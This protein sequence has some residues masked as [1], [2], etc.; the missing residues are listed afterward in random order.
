MRYI[1]VYIY[2]LIYIYLC[3]FRYKSIYRNLFIF[4]HSKAAVKVRINRKKVERGRCSIFTQ[5][6]AFSF[7]YFSRDFVQHFA[8]RNWL[9]TSHAIRSNNH[10]GQ[11]EWGR[12]ECGDCRILTAHYTIIFNKQF[13]SLSFFYRDSVAGEGGRQSKSFGAC[14]ELCSCGKCGTA[15]F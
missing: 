11:G 10:R 4:K 9:S 13:S 7:Y 6:K 14:C 8:A 5:L 2:S 12:R 15:C 1:Y 3:R